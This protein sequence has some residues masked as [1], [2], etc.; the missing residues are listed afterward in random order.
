[1]RLYVTCL[2]CGERFL[3][4]EDDSYEELCD[5]CSAESRENVDF[6]VTSEDEE[7]AP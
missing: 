7:A 3:Y 6:N 5:R 1:M 4:D 2:R